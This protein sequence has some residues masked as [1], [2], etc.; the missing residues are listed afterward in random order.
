MI[1][2]SS[3][4]TVFPDPVSRQ[5]IEEHSG[6]KISTC[7]QC[8]KCTNG[9]PLT[10]AMDIF[11]HQ[12]M[13]RIHLGATK[14]VLDSDTIWVCASCETCTARCPNDIDI[15]H[16]MDTLRQLS[17]ARGVK[18]SQKKAPVFHS[19]FLSSVKRLGRMH[20]M[21]MALEFALKSEGI[22]GISRQAGMGLAMLRKGKL[23]LL[24]GRWRAGKQV[25]GIF[26]EAKGKKKA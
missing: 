11:P 7:F 20:E 18:P 14:E 22:K 8:E 2:Q 19:T 13:H 26:R 16:V 15:A 25:N 4:K 23:N 21:S 3:F 9:C 5:Q 12:I 1:V 6:Q 10:F 17:A 24:P